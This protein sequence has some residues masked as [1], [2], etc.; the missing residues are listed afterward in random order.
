MSQATPSPEASVVCPNCG[1]SNR[2]EARFCYRCRTP[3]VGATATTLPPPA[4]PEGQGSVA[5]TMTELQLPDQEMPPAETPTVTGPGETT[6]PAQPRPQTETQ[7]LARVPTQAGGT[8][9]LGARPEFPPRPD[10]SFFNRRYEFDALIS[11]DGALNI[12]RVWD[13][14]PLFLCANP[15]CTLR[16]V[17]QSS[18]EGGT[19]MQCSSPL[20]DGR[21][22]RKRIKESLA[23]DVLGREPEIA[24]RGLAHAGLLA[25][26][27]YFTERLGPDVR[28]CVVSPEPPSDRASGLKAPQPLDAVLQWGI[29]LADGLDHLHEHRI[30]FVPAGRSPDAMAEHFAF[31]AYGAAWTDFAACHAWP[32]EVT[33]ETMR[34]DI[35]HDQQSL[36]AELL[37]LLT[38]SRELSDGA[39]RPGALHPKVREF[40]HKALTPGEGFVSAADMKAALVELRE[41][42]VA[43]EPTPLK[44]DLSIGRAT[45]VGQVRQLNEDSVMVMEMVRM[46]EST[47]R[48]LGLFV[49]ADGMG[50]QQS[51][52]VASRVAI[53]A[54]TA[55][56]ETELFSPTPPADM[57]AWVVSTMEAAHE[58]VAERRAAAQSDMGSTLVMAVVSGGTASVASI[59]D[60]R[61]YLVEASGEMA[62]LTTDDSLVQRLL[63]ANQITPEEARQ[64]PKRSVI[65]RALGTGAFKPPDVITREIFLGDRLLLCSDGLSSMLDDTVIAQLASPAESATPQ[66][67]CGR[68]IEAA[69]ASGGE[70]NVSVILVELSPIP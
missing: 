24:Q 61:A 50:G 55:R 67:A 23:P 14:R 63:A 9:P 41:V 57:G 54:I 12:Y 16:G 32:L 20:I 35:A 59:G 33:A 51:G 17:L 66:E 11:S 38:G 69:N 18:S 40:F 1:A 64:H 53:E 2:P 10:G 62:Q 52:E 43:A 8:R 27:Q 68:L 48:P 7:P 44:V 65:L 60:S 49:V 36:A 37:R 13:T 70:D 58:A 42:V 34:D 28:H 5:D 21:N 4:A 22:S 30:T 3:L 39:M 46:H 47:A 45:H 25:P 56:A 29:E 15:D 6:L 26:T 19:C 31:T